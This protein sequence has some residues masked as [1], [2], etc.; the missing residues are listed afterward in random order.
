MAS[1]NHP[2]YKLRK[3]MNNIKHEPKS[4]FNKRDIGKVIF[5]SLEDVSE[6]L[7]DV[8]VITE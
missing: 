2:R 7:G 3:R 5:Y 8:V 1:K 6:T 4:G